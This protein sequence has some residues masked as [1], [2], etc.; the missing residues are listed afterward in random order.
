MICVYVFE[1]MKAQQWILP[2]KQ[3]SLLTTGPLLHDPS[4]TGLQVSDSCQVL[5]FWSRFFSHRHEY[6]VSYITAINKYLLAN[7]GSGF[8][9]GRKQ[10]TTDNRRCFFY[11]MNA[12]IGRLYVQTFHSHG[13]SFTLFSVSVM[14]D[15]CFYDLVLK[16]FS[17]THSFFSKRFV[18][19]PTINEQN[20][21]FGDLYT[22]FLSKDFHVSVNWDSFNDAH[23]H[24]HKCTLH[25][26]LACMHFLRCI[27]IFHVTFLLFRGDVNINI[28]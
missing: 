5:S 7:R 20:K 26:I 15:W 16:L 2:M 27:P 11:W 8:F 3:H 23:T 18:P 9:F 13:D 6:F 25:D 12:Y 10:H 1:R 24:T 17:E 4:N 14:M 22:W 28:K 21:Y 19:Y